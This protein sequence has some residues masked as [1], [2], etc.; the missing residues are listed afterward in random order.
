MQS[1]IYRLF[2]ATVDGCFRQAATAKNTT[3]IFE[4]RTVSG[5]LPFEIKNGLNFFLKDRNILEIS[6]DFWIFRHLC[7]S[8][9]CLYRNP[10]IYN[11]HN[12]LARLDD[13]TNEMPTKHLM[14]QV[15]SFF[16]ISCKILCKNPFNLFSYIFFFI[17][18]QK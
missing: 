15:L 14:F 11:I 12:T 3:S 1:Q 18:L 5:Q 4:L 13:G 6:S 2:L 17:K 16:M 9:I 10:S 7:H 8:L